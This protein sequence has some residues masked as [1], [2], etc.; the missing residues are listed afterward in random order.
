MYGARDLSGHNKNSYLLLLKLLLVIS[1]LSSCAPS[2]KFLLERGKRIGVDKSYVRVLINSSS[3]RCVISS[4]SRI[5]ITEL[6]S[7]KINYD[8]NGRTIY[9]YPEMIGV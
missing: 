6:K 8:G 7:R 1:I 3:D 2:R 5:K 4:N 9:F